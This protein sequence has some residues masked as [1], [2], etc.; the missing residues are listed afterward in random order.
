M[1]CVG[2]GGK[3]AWFVAKYCLAFCIV[4]IFHFG[5]YLKSTT[6]IKQPLPKE[7]ERKRKLNCL[8]KVRV[9]KMQEK[10]VI[11]ANPSLKKSIFVDWH[12]SA[13]C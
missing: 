4:N 8:V 3:G 9:S 6:L 7:K 10:N 5:V 1:I 13:S 12:Y 2:G 11:S